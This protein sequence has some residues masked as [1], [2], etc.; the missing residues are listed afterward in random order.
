[1]RLF[2]PFLFISIIFI[3]DLY[4]Q[5]SISPT[6]WYFGNGAG[7]DFSTDPPRTIY[8]GKIFTLE[9]CASACDEDGK[10]LLYTDG[11][12]L[13]NKHHREIPNGT[14]LNGSRSSTQGALIVPQPGASLKYFV[15]VMDEKAGKNGL[16]YS[17]VDMSSAEGSVTGKNTRLLEAS[18]EQMTATRMAGAEGFWVIT[19]RWNSNNYLVYPVTAKG[20]GTPVV[21]AVGSIR[22]ETGSGEN[23]EAIGSLCVS[24]D[25]TKVASTICYRAKDNLELLDFNVVTGKLS[26]PRTMTLNGSPYGACFSPGGTKLYVSFLKGPSGIIQYDLTDNSVT[27]V[28]R[29]KADNSFGTLQLGPDWKIYVARTEDYMGVIDR[30]DGKGSTCKYIPGAIDLSPVTG[31][32]GLPNVFLSL[33]ETV[34]VKQPAQ[35]NIPVEPVAAKPKTPP[36]ASETSTRSDCANVIER[37]FTQKNQMTMTDV[38]VCENEYLLSAKNFGGSFNWSTLETTQQIT[39]KRSGL[40]KVSV[41]LN[42]CSVTDSIRVRFRKEA[43]QFTFLPSF[44]PETEFLN[45]EFYYEIDDVSGF[46]M[47]IF[48]RRQNEIFSTGNFKKKWNGRNVKGN[49]VPAGDYSWTVK[50][51]PNC[52]KDSKE[53]IKEGKVNVKRSKK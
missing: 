36:P 26:D 35:P 31:N 8:D 12:T 24:S 14:G 23:R 32:F 43:S 1:M 41:T 49:L 48:D 10:L 27:E 33:V 9:G 16:S 30:P 11:L 50:Y 25:G 52:P 6:V 45:G 47:K 19:H 53:V 7:V 40:Y 42:G 38:S 21:S 37:P 22:S 2:L 3:C 44:N 4:G 51:K 39:V 18:T 17:R 13:W 34:P 29:S 5:N 20:I 28:V 46:E 15:F